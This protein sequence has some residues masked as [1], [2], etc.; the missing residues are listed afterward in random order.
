MTFEDS[1]YLLPEQ[2]ARQRIDAMLEAAGWVLQ[3]YRSSLME[4]E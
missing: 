3:D 2:K 4:E 1:D